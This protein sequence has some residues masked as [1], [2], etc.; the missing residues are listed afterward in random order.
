MES[1]ISPQR[2]QRGCAATEEDS[3]S[4]D[5]TAKGAKNA[6]QKIGVFRV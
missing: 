1:E 5:L 4:N 2:A 6:K 3:E